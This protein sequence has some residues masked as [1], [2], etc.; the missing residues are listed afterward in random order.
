MIIITAKGVIFLSTSVWSKLAPLRKYSPLSEDI[1]ADVAVIGGGIAGILTAYKLSERKKNIVVLE[2][3]EIC[4]GQ[5]KNTTAKIT[6]QHDLIYDYI[7]KNFGEKAAGQYAAANDAA[8]AEYKNIIENNSIECDF[9]QKDAYLYTSENPALLEAE[10]KAAQAAGIECEL[11]TKVNLPFSVAMALKFPNQA[12]FHPLK[13]LFAIADKLNIY[14]HTFAREIKDNTIFTQNGSVKAE[15]IIVATHYPYINKHGFYFARMHQERSYVISLENAADVNGMYKGIDK[16]SFSF[17]NYENLLIFGGGSHRTGENT[18]GGMYENLKTAAK[19]FY[20]GCSVVDYWS[21]QD[22]FTVDFI[23]YIGK[24]CTTTPDIYVA[25]GFKKWGMTSSMV[26]AMILSDMLCGTENPYSE[27]FSPQ[28][29]KLSASAKNILSEGLEAVK[30]LGK[31]FFSFPDSEAEKL[32]PGHGGIVTYK[33]EKLGVYKDE[34]G[35]VFIVEPKCTHLG[36]ELSFNPDEKSWDCPC[37]GSRFDYRGNLID[38][39]A[40]ENLECGEN[41]KES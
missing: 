31:R 26:S 19:N 2:A 12:Q 29:F 24:Y 37:H 18:A 4:G 9:C 30:M 10:Q 39:P 20:P 11:T 38:N 40:M 16:H 3:G 1:E 25:T 17:R 41:N 14:E 15:K 36:C 8:I 21:A 32:P 35:E 27:I 5:T 22:C 23:P 33:G 34:C 7:I 28:R 13:F 6:S